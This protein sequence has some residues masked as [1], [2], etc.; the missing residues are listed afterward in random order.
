MSCQKEIPFALPDQGL[1]VLYS[2]RFNQDFPLD[3]TFGAEG[4]SNDPTSW[5][6]KLAGGAHPRTKINPIIVA[7]PQEF[8]YWKDTPMTTINQLNTR[9]YQYPTLSG[10]TITDLVDKVPISQRKDLNGQYPIV[11]PLIQDI[12]PGVYTL[13]DDY[14][15]INANLGIS[16]TPQFVPITETHLKG[17]TIFSHE[18]QGKRYKPKKQENFDQVYE[19]F[20]P[21]LQEGSMISRR[22][23]DNTE[24]F[25][26]I[27]NVYDPRFSG[28]GSDN[29]SYYEQT[30]GQQRYFYDDVQ[31]IRMPNYVIRSKIDSCVTPFGDEYGPMRQQ[32]LTLNETRPLAEK[33]YLENNMFHRNDMMES[34]MRKRNRE[35]WQEREAPKYDLSTGARHAG[36]F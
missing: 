7:R 6:Q 34:L 21:S 15:P 5:N 12:Q 18:K 16:E 24:E 10:Y 20:E 29:R 25:P 19:P 22:P 17:N 28:Y 35:M 26:N 11:N 31:A 23:H 14:Q 1:T 27:Y 32:Q 9:K 4:S 3:D 13:P 30:V 36:V 33:Y 2:N 8:E